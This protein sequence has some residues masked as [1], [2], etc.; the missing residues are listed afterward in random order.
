MD[1]HEFEEKLKKEQRL[2]K[3][4]ADVIACRNQQLSELDHKLSDL[5]ANYH[6]LFVE[7]KV[8]ENRLL[9]LE[10]MKLNADRLREEVFYKQSVV[11]QLTLENNL[12]NKSHSKGMFVFIVNWC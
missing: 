8:K 6:K 2:S 10:Q 5:K 12:L 7:S 11:R 4:L 9:V 1:N 3:R